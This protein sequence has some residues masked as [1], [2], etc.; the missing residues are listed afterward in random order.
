MCQRARRA[1]ARGRPVRPARLRRRPSRG[2]AR[3][4]R[5]DG[6]IYLGSFSK[7]FAP[8]LRVGWAVAP[9]A[10]R[11]KLVLAAEASVLCP[12]AFT[13]LAVSAYLAEHPWLDQVKVFRE[14]YRERRDAMLDALAGSDARRHAP[15]PSPTAASTLGDAARRAWTRRRCC[16]ARSPRGWRTSRAR[17][18]TPTR[19]S[20]R[21]PSLRLS[22]CY[23]EPDRIREGVRRLAGVIEEE[24]ELLRDVRHRGARCNR[25]RRLRPSDVP[26]PETA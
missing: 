6:V 5:R 16:R 18:S 19:P 13:Q 1:G 2:A 11:E 26:G 12:P 14:M 23:P 21:P 9:H 15:G 4:R 25:H 7:T 20:R 22:Y 8:G 10:V 17:R 24:L 3:R